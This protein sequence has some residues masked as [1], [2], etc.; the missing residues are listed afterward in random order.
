MNERLNGI[1]VF[2]HAV[3][4][5][6]FSSAATRL[7]LTRSAVTKTIAR[8]EDRLGVR[9]FHRTT[10]S[11]SLT[12]AGQAYYEHCARA[13]AEL[14]AGEATVGTG[15]HEPTGRLRISVPVLFGRQ[16]VAPLMMEL[17]RRYP[18]LVI[19]VSF[20]DRVVDL[21]D[22]GFDIGLR[23]GPLADSTTLAARPLGPQRMLICAAPSYLQQH[24]RPDG[25]QDIARHAGILYTRG[26]TVKQWEIGAA[27]GKARTV[28][29]IQRML[30]DDL[31]AIADA[32]VAGLGLAW[33][34]CW[35]MSPY[36]NRG[37]LEVLFDCGEMEASQMH[38]VWPHSPHM[39]AK[40]R[41]AIDTLLEVA[42]YY[43]GKAER[44]A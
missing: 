16:F 25:E 36:V 17:A 40:L 12:D 15:R 31:Q 21:I 32:A 4:A 2:V 39:P 30:L 1:H 24:G 43:L 5:G 9:L 7:H 35:L 18:Q 22:E 33:L 3:E 28:M 13:I 37:E 20:N 11:Q 27:G 41:V 14:D 42:P 34:P 10:R 44:L 8:L 19:D 38:L 6:S 26:R 23:V 29:P